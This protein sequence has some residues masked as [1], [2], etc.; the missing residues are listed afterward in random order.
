MNPVA[1]GVW[2]LVAI[3]VGTLQGCSERKMICS[4]VRARGCVN[5]VA[6]PSATCPQM[7]AY[8]KCI[9]DAG[10]CNFQVT[11]EGGQQASGRDSIESILSSAAYVGCKFSNPC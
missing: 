2:I 10:C 11:M 5:T 6:W 8:A 4:E 9:K 3:L 7:T 1:S